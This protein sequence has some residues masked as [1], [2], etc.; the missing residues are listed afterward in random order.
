M[1]MAEAYKG[2]EIIRFVLEFTIL[3]HKCSEYSVFV[4]DISIFIVN[5]LIPKHADMIQYNVSRIFIV[6]HSKFGLD[7]FHPHGK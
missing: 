3:V 6:T 7:I 5:I 2:V 1:S 4:H